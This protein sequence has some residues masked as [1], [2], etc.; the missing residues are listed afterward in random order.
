[1]AGAA[2]VAAKARAR[3]LMRALRDWAE[4]KT[5]LGAMDGHVLGFVHV[6]PGKEREDSVFG[7]GLKPLHFSVSENLA[8]ESCTNKGMLRD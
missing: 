5:G 2:F 3:V 6:A 1:M 8:V 4:P 7:S